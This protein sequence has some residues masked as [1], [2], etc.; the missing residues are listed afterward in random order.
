MSVVSNDDQLPSRARNSL[1]DEVE[2]LARQF[3]SHPGFMWTEEGLAVPHPD[4]PAYPK[5]AGYKH[6]IAALA[7]AGYRFYPLDNVDRCTLFLVDREP[8]ST[9]NNYNT[10]LYHVAIWDADLRDCYRRELLSGLSDLE[11]PHLSYPQGFLSLTAK[12]YEAV[13][14][15]DLTFDL[16]PQLLARV[17]TLLYSALFDTAIREAS[18]LLEGSLRDLVGAGRESYGLQLVEKCFGRKSQIFPDSMTNA[19]RLELR[20]EFRLFFKHI[21]NQISH[22]DLNLDDIT[23]TRILRRCSNLLRVVESF[24]CGGEGAA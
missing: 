14:I 21:R 23:C 19:E 3:S 7:D 13:R 2:A 22:G 16:A 1:V 18:V 4:W 11:E 17:E 15:H 9:E 6:A 12:A 24:R 20:N 5:G 8:K 10:D